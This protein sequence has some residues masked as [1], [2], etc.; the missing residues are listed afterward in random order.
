MFLF[1]KVVY[2]QERV[3][4]TCDILSITDDEHKLLD[5]ITGGM[6]SQRL[7]TRD[8]FIGGL[9]KV[10]DPGIKA[11]QGFGMTGKQGGRHMTPIFC[12]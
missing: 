1:S 9:P 10:P 4:I 3:S 6:V 12:F 11:T 8:P 7:K 5:E 2:I